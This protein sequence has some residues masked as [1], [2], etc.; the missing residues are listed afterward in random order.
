MELYLLAN[1][2]TCGSYFKIITALFTF[3]DVFKVVLMDFAYYH[4]CVVIVFL[5]LV[6]VFNNLTCDIIF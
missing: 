1:F 5:L 4:S 2:K 3:V 6:L